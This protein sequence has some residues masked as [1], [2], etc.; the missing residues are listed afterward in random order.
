MT[1]QRLTDKELERLFLA[2]TGLDARAF[3]EM[4]SAKIVISP[5][6]A[7]EWSYASKLTALLMAAS[8]TSVN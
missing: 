5:A 7:V 4:T 1:P 6:G 3:A 8:Y 2:N